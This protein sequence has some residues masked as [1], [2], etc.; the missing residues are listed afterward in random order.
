MI[1]L[2]GR[3]WY[4]TD[5]SKIYFLKLF[6][7]SFITKFLTEVHKCHKIYLLKDKKNK[8]K[9]CIFNFVVQFSYAVLH[10]IKMSICLC[11]FEVN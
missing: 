3:G 9:L 5:D 8:E 10:D 6:E 4:E 11:L 2:F 7:M 1:Y